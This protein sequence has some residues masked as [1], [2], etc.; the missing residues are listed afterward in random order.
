MNEMVER[1]ARA[2]WALE[3]NTDCHEWEPLSEFRKD[4]TREKARAAISAMREPTDEMVD[5]A[6]HATHPLHG[7]DPASRWHAMI[8]AALK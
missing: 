2:L 1:V 7:I 8:D 5:A 3:E 6:L 4:A